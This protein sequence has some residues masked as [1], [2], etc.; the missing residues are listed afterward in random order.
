MSD[1]DRRDHRDLVVD[2]TAFAPRLAANPAFIDFDVGASDADHVAAL[3]DHSRPQL[4]QNLEG[5]LVAGEAKLALKLHRRHTAGQR[6]NEVSA[7]EPRRERRAG[8]LHDRSRCQARIRSTFPAPQHA[9]ASL[10]AERFMA[11]GA[12]RTDKALRPADALKIVGA[13]RIVREQALELRQRTGERERHLRPPRINLGLGRAVIG[14]LFRTPHTIPLVFFR[15]FGGKLISLALGFGMVLRLNLTRAAAVHK[16]F[17]LE[18]GF[19]PKAHGSAL[20]DMKAHQPVATLDSPAVRPANPD[21]ANAVKKRQ[22]LTALGHSER[23]EAAETGKFGHLKHRKI[24]FD[25]PNIALVSVGVNRIGMLATIKRISALEPIPNADTIELANMEDSGWQ[26]VVKKGIHTVGDLVCYCE[27]DSWVPTKVAP[28]L[29]KAGHQPKTFR[30]VEGE[31]LKTIKLRG[32]LSQGVIIPLSD[33]TKDLEQ[34]VDEVTLNSMVTYKPTGESMHLLPQINNTPDGFDCT[35]LLGIIKYEKP[36]PGELVGKAR[37]NFP[38]FI[39][40]TDQERVQNLWGKLQY[41]REQFPDELFEVTEKLDGSS[42]TVYLVKDETTNSGLRLG[43]CSRNW[44]LDLDAEGAEETKFVRA[45]LESNVFDRMVQFL[46]RPVPCESRFDYYQ[47]ALQGE[48]VGP[49]VQGNKY[50]LR[51]LEFRIFDMFN[52]NV[53]QYVTAE[54]RHGD[55]LTIDMLHVPVIE[56]RKLDFE[57]IQD[58]LAYA[59]GPSSLNPKVMREGVVFKSLQDPSFSFKVISNEWLLKNE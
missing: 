9:G 46:W 18:P 53:Q 8:S 7:P 21:S 2:T 23:R 45:A 47:V 52:I 17:R 39:P 49:G 13:R 35:K 15:H 26:V 42:M 24:S 4:V 41:R 59:Y 32:T 22:R 10:K 25:A 3:A 5:R 48:L 37:G 44:D 38:S 29:T 34:G 55:E 56:T 57:T 30:G 51:E 1:F 20:H 50:D 14:Q 33:I 16:V 54:T 11:N 12:L 6:R 58:I 36:L 43:V 28:W 31:R 27:T 40:K 19:D